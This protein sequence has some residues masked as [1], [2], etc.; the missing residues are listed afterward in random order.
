MPEEIK[1]EEVEVWFQEGDSD[2][3][4]H[5]KTGELLGSKELAKR[6][7][8]NYRKKYILLTFVNGRTIL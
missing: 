5:F 4:R 1:P 2:H 3:Y 7:G 8:T 6:E